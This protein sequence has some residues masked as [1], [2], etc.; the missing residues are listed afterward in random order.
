[1]SLIGT[2][3]GALVALVPARKDPRDIEIERLNRS[4]AQLADHIE[5]L[6]R[7]IA[8][9]RSLKAHWRDEAKRI[10]RQARETRQQ[11]ER[12]ATVGWQEHAAQAFAQESQLLALQ[13][14]QQTFAAQAQAQQNIYNQG[15]LG[16]HAQQNALSAMQAQHYASM[17]PSD[18]GQGQLGQGRSPQNMPQGAFD[19]FCNCVPSRAQVWGAQ[20]GLVQRLNDR[21]A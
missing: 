18:L 1:M 20:H 5:D 8:I 9:Q 12:L 21:S 14:A 17:V 19:G 15:M 6:E 13:A 10:A 2:V 16:Q 11:R 4:H 3:I 7:E